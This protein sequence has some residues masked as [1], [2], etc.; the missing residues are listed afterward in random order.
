MEELACGFEFIFKDKR[1]RKEYMNRL[2]IVAVVLSLVGTASAATLQ[3]GARGIEAAPGQEVLI[4]ARGPEAVLGVNLYIQIG[5]GGAGNVPPGTDV[6]GVNVARL[7]TVDFR[8]NNAIWGADA[9]GV[10]DPGLQDALIAFGGIGLN[11]GTKQLPNVSTPEESAVVATLIL[12][13]TGVPVGTKFMISFSPYGES[14]SLVPAP[15]TQLIPGEITIIPE[16]ASA[17]LLLAALAPIVR[18]RR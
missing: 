4:L 8:A 9:A 15:T 10:E 11:A 17:L 16:P 5:D 13:G 3:V 14:S 2:L 7:Q 6:G 1:R 12:D 18:R